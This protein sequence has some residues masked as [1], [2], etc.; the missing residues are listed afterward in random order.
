MSSS[1]IFFASWCVTSDDMPGTPPSQVGRW[2]P[3]SPTV[4]TFTWLWRERW[5][6]SSP[7]NV[8]NR[9]A[10]MPSMRAPFAMISPGYTPSSEPRETM[11]ETLSMVSLMSTP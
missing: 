1:S 3:G 7:K 2:R 4:E 9:F 10:S 5:I 11:M 6:A 8:K